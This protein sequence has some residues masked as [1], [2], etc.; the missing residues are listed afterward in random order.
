AETADSH[1]PRAGHFDGVLELHADSGFRSVGRPAV[2]A[3]SALVTLAAQES[4]LFRLYISKA[5]NVNAVGAVAEG[6]FVLVTGRFSAGACAD[7]MEAESVAEL[8]AG[9]GTAVG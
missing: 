9:M 6:H 8:A 4:L 7:V 2:A 3:S 1:A 5:R